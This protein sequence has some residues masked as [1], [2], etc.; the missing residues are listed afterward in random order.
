VQFT[1]AKGEEA[2]SLVASRSLWQVTESHV[3]VTQWETKQASK[4]QLESKHMA[5]YMLLQISLEPP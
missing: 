2:L 3:G 4:K 5:V 1:I